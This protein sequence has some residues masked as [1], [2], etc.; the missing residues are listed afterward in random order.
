MSF[1]NF[2]NFL[3]WGPSHHSFQNFPQKKSD[4]ETG[5]FSYPYNDPTNATYTYQNFIGDGKEGANSN[6]VQ[7]NGNWSYNETEKV[8]QFSSNLHIKFPQPFYYEKLWNNFYKKAG[9]CVLGGAIITG[10]GLIDTLPLALEILKKTFPSQSRMIFCTRLVATCLFA[11][12]TGLCYIRQQQAN[13]LYRIAYEATTES[14]GSIQSL[15]QSVS[16]ART[17][18]YTTSWDEWEKKQKNLSEGECIAPNEKEYSYCLYLERFLEQQLSPT[19]NGLNISESDRTIGCKTLL[20]KDGPFGHRFLKS[21][22]LKTDILQKIK[23]YCDS[24]IETKNALEEEFSQTVKDE[25]RIRSKE[26]CARAIKSYFE[27]LESL[28]D[29]GEFMGYE[30]SRA[31]AQ[32]TLSYLNPTKGFETNINPISRLE[33]RIRQDLNKILDSHKSEDDEIYEF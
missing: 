16:K 33:L 3:I 32:M 14:Q 1:I 18:F 20:S 29:L 28:Q 27:K 17:E 22:S 6:Q 11:F 8:Y 25:Q 23:E 24:L 2:T 26:A 7:V 19:A 31:V 30:W 10:K 13:R 5:K 4:F 12:L 21:E 9:T 15:F